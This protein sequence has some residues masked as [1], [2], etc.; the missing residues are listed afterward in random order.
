MSFFSFSPQGVFFVYWLVLC[1]IGGLLM[2][3]DK[4]RAKHHRWRISERSLMLIALVGGA[5]GIWVG[6]RTAHHKTRKPLFQIMVPLLFFIQLLFLI[7][8]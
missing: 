7:Y 4:Y 8:L 3:I 5:G 6:M 1:I 2:H